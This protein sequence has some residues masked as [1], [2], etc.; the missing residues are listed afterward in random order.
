MSKEITTFSHEIYRVFCMF[1]VVAGRAKQLDVVPCIGAASGQGLYVVN[2]IRDADRN[3]TTSTF[4]SLRSSYILDVC[5]GEPAGGAFLSGSPQCVFRF[6]PFWMLLGIL[7]GLFAPFH[8]IVLVVQPIGFQAF[9]WVIFSPSRR[10][11]SRSGPI[12]FL[13]LDRTQYVRLGIGVVAF[14]T[15][16]SLPLYVLVVS[17]SLPLSNIY[18]ICFAIPRS[19]DCS[20]G[21]VGRDSNQ[22][23]SLNGFWNAHQD[24]MKKVAMVAPI[25]Q[26]QRHRLGVMARPMSRAY[27]FLVIFQQGRNAP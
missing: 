6:F 19:D 9:F 1:G 8:A 2:V 12:G 18:A 17:V 4:P 3:P 14:F 22:I 21:S 20:P 23:T 11:R 10:C 13:P 26:G 25:A 7:K 27:Y 5:L 24:G 15:S 16:F